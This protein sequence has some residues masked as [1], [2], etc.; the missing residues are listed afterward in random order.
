M[1]NSTIWLTPVISVSPPTIKNVAST[2]TPPITSGRNARNEPKTSA[3]ITSAPIDPIIVS[4]MIPVPRDVGAPSARRSSPV[5]PKCHP[6]GS[7]ASA[8]L[9]IAPAGVGLPVNEVAAGVNTSAN[10]V[11]PSLVTN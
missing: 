3:R 9:V 8:A 10:V 1:R 11:R 2:E 4:T 5:S 7:A 6:R